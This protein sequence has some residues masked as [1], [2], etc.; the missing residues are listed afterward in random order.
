MLAKLFGSIAL[1]VFSDVHNPSAVFEMPWHAEI[2][3]MTVHLHKEGVFSWPDWTERFSNALA[4]AGVH[5][6]LN[7]SNDYY[8]IWLDTFI[9]F[10]AEKGVTNEPAIDFL[11]EKWR[12]AYLCTPHGMPV[13]LT[14]EI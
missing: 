1:V 10:I 6:N 3:A 11:S 4:G 7:G 12:K 2:F 8:N 14:K 5:H 9:Q 13:T